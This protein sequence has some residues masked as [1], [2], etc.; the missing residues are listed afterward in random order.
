MNLDN[1]LNAAQKYFPGVNIQYKN[2]S[3]F[4][5]ILGKILFFNKSFMS[6]Y[7]TTINSTIYFPNRDFIKNNYNSFIVTFLHEL[8]HIKDAKK[9]SFI[10]FSLLYLSPQILTLLIIPFIFLNWKL[11]LIFLIFALPIPSFF[12]MYFERRAYIVSLYVLNYLIVNHKIRANLEDNKNFYLTQF[13][14]SGYYFMWPFKNIDTKL[15][16]AVDNIKLNKR[17]YEDPIF[18]IVDDL[19]K[20]I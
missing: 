18:D 14:L 5:K 12:R 16:L 4:M 19:L 3:T 13:K 1:L 8:V 9:F 17:P 11:S 2:E 20:Q 15:S 10:L 6:N 7:T